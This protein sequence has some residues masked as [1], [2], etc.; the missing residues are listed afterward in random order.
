MRCTTTGGSNA[1]TTVWQIALLAFFLLAPIVSAVYLAR[2]ARD[3]PALT[4]SLF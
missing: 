1:A 4:A 3:R 2:R